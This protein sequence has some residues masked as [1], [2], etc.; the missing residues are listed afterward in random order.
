ML[1]L[2]IAYVS[3][4]LVIACKNI[5][6]PIEYFKFTILLE[7][8]NALNKGHHV[9]YY[10]TKRFATYVGINCIYIYISLALPHLK[11][12]EFKSWNKI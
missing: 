5:Y 7:F 8:S 4:K 1:S 6:I 2:Q 10:V 12:K 9:C 3:T 11:N